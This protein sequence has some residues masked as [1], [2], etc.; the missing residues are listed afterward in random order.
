MSRLIHQHSSRTAAPMYGHRAYIGT[1]MARG[2]VTPGLLTQVKAERA[3]RAFDPALSECDRLP[4]V[5]LNV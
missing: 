1:S 5:L 4:G 2:P 3:R